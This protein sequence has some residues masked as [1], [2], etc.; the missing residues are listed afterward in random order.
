MSKWRVCRRPV[1]HWVYWSCSCSARRRCW[2]RHAGH[3]GCHRSWRRVLFEVW[4]PWL[5]VHRTKGSMTMDS[6]RCSRPIGSEAPR[7]IM[8]ARDATGVFLTS[9]STGAR[10]GLRPLLIVGGVE[11]AH[12]RWRWRY[13]HG[14]LSARHRHR[15]GRDD[16]RPLGRPVT[17]TDP[18]FVHPRAGIE[19]EE[20]S[21]GFTAA[22]GVASRRVAAGVRRLAREVRSRPDLHGPVAGVGE[23]PMEILVATQRNRIAGRECANDFHP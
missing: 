17:R 3:P 21:H 12:P 4:L 1:W 22:R 19:Q 14:L 11:G 6:G 5:G 16:L 2:Y 7:M 23:M 20:P 10:R 18:Y 9:R 8:N 13:L 15:I